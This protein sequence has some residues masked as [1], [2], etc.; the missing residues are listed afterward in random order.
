MKAV[1]LAAAT[2]IFASSFLSGED[3]T[4]SQVFNY[5]VKVYNTETYTSF[6]PVLNPGNI[7][8]SFSGLT[9][10]LKYYLDGRWK[11]GDWAVSASDIGYLQAVT[12]F[13]Y[14]NLLTEGYVSY[15]F[16]DIFVDAGKKKITQSVCFIAFPIDFALNSYNDVTQNKSY[17]QQ[18]SEGRFMANI[19]WYSDFGI[20]G[21]SYI[22]EIDFTNNTTA[23]FSS[24]QIQQ[25][26]LRYSVDISGVD[27]GLALSYDN[28]WR[29]GANISATIGDYFEVHAEGAYLQDIARFGFVTNQIVTGFDPV[30]MQNIYSPQLSDT[31]N[32]VSNVCQFIL[33]TTYN[34][35]YFSIMAEYY[36]NMAGYNY[37][38][39]QNIRNSMKDFRSAYDSQPANMLNV[40][41]LGSLMSFAGTNNILNVCQNYGF[42]RVS[43][44]TSEKLG[45]SW[46]TIL[47]LE[48]LSG[49]EIFEASYSGWDNAT[50][51]GQ[52]NFDFGDPYSEFRLLGQDWSVSIIL[53]LCI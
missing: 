2:L 40:G 26:E 7:F 19:D 20:I 1:L 43:N 34:G 12:N 33:G 36:Y 10:G 21:L 42:I 45:L 9:G 49:M 41:N 8:G 27:A 30:L 32:T 25:E 52:F 23:Y 15:H 3:P 50:L 38:Q 4:N 6:N 14:T 48:D 13:P 53:E 11:S 44:P 18:F 16:W 24:A 29:T 17:D 47:N 5:N 31:E 46:I 51:T 37:D 22:P 39:W 35:E 28:I